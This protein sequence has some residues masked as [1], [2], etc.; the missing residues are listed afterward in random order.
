MKKYIGHIIGY[1]IE[2]L[3]VAGAYL[4]KYFTGKKMGMARYVIFK[5]QSWER[6][7]PLAQWTGISILLLIILL[8]FTVVLIVRKRKQLSSFMVT[9]GLLSV[10]LTGYSLYFTIA[11]SAATLRPYY[12]MS[13]LIAIAA[14]VQLIKSICVLLKINQ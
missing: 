10:A 12:W 7:Y 13:P 6:Q 5:N 1:A 11:N 14:L 4:V 3:L 8:I 9:D 2:L